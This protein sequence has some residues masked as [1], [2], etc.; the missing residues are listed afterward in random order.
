MN[1]EFVQYKK[2]GIIVLAKALD[3]ICPTFNG[4][5][6]EERQLEIDRRINFFKT[7]EVELDNEWKELEKEA[8]SELKDFIKERDSIF[9]KIVKTNNSERIKGKI[10][11]FE[12]KKQARVEYLARKNEREVASLN[13]KLSEAK[14]GSKKH[15]QL[16]AKLKD[17]EKDMQSKIK[18]TEI[19]Y[20]TIIKNTM[21]SDNS[22][23][24]ELRLQQSKEV[25]E[26]K[27]KELEEKHMAKESIH[28]T[29]RMEFDQIRIAMKGFAEEVEYFKHWCTLADI[30]LKEC[31]QE[32]IK[33]AKM[34]GRSTKEL[35]GVLQNII[36]G[37]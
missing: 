29:K 31:Y 5:P 28:N 7:S 18:K 25:W 22:E 11:G 26:R 32:A 33:R 21:N 6:E 24:V 19:R 15:T 3:D 36:L 12:A 27:Y 35:E 14:E 16:M 9:S 1:E 10:A 13:Q 30:T 8:T 2:L 34:I 20:N 23:R 17:L 37:V 4:E